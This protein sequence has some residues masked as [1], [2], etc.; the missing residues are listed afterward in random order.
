MRILQPQLVAETED[1]IAINKPSGMLTLPDRHDAEKTS[2]KGWVLERYPEAMVVH[3]L[4]KETSGLLL[5]PRCPAAHQ[6]FSQLFESRNIR[7]IYKALIAGK[8]LEATGSIDAP[9]AEHPAKKWQH[10]STPKRKKQLNH[11]HG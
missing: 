4:D 6:Y 11:L 2:L 10:D 1:Y 9:I 5:F 3:R 7:K 8:P